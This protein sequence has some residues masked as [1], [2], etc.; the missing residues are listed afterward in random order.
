MMDLEQPISTIHRHPTQDLLAVGSKGFTKLVRIQNGEFKPPK[1]LKLNKTSSK[2]GTTDVQFNPSYYNILASTTLLNN[3]IIIWDIDQCNLNKLSTNIGQHDQLVNRVSWNPINPKLLASCSQDGYIK[4]FDFINTKGEVLSM[5]HRD[6]VRDCQFSPF[7]EHLLL[8]SYS[9]VVKLWDTR[10]TTRSVQDFYKHEADVLSIDWNPINKDIFIAGSMDKSFTLWDI[11][12]KEPCR[13]YKT[14]FGFSRIKFWKKNPQYILTSFQTNNNFA[15][16][17]NLEIQN[18]AEYVFKGHKEVV[19]GFCWD[20][21]ETKLI[22]VSKDSKMILHDFYNGSRPLDNFYTNFCKLNDETQLYYYTDLLPNKKPLDKLPEDYNVLYKPRE[23]KDRMI[24]FKHLKLSFS[25]DK[26]TVKEVFKRFSFLVRIEYL[27][28]DVLIKKDLL[29][30]TS[31]PKSNKNILFSPVGN[32]K[33]TD[34][35]NLKLIIL[36]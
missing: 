20:L 26:D 19:T 22:T 35:F 9:G 8:A 7:N 5:N 32:S 11:N 14:N 25:Y 28:Q 23:K 33:N 10:D 27:R 4:I 36:K 6:K 29:E 13:S 16:L 34:N 17:W 31:F 12:I 21:S 15:Y 3:Q 18:I 30:K 1:M 24:F 2:S